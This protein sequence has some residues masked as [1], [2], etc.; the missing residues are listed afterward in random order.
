[1][2]TNSVRANSV[3]STWRGRWGALGLAAILYAVLYT[4]WTFFHWGGEENV[5]YIADFASVPIGLL[6]AFAAWR[7]V[8]DRQL[9]GG[10]RRAWLILGL[11]VF[12]SALGEALWFLYDALLKVQP[13]PSLADAFYLPFYPLVFLGLL[14]IPNAPMSREA[15]AKFWLDLAIV[16]TVA[17]MF[18]WYFIVAP[19]LTEAEGDLLSQVLAAAYPIG[20]LMAM[21][22]VTVLVLRR[23]D[24]TTR[25]ALL[26]FSCGLIV[27]LGS[28]LYFA[29]ASLFGDYAPGTF[30]E[31]GFVVGYALYLL[32]ALEQF[33]TTRGLNLSRGRWL[34]AVSFA[35]PFVAVALGYGLVLFAYNAEPDRGGRFWDLFVVAAVLALLVTAR[36]VVAVREIELLSGRLRVASDDLR[37]LSQDLERRV[38]DRTR[39]LALAA[40][41]SRNVSQVRN[42]D[43]LLAEAVELIR[44]QFDLYYTQV[45][46]TDP[47]GKSLILRAGTGST[48]DELLHRSHRLPVGPGSLHGRAASEKQ[49]C[50][51]ADTSSDASFHPNPLLPLTR[52]EMAIPLIV[53]EQVVGVLDLQHN[54][55]GAFTPDKLPA[56]EAL[57]GQLAVAI[58]NAALFA[59]AEQ[60]RAEVE[61]QARRLTQSGWS[62][63]LNAV[64]RSERVGYAFDANG[65]SPIQETIVPAPD[66]ST[67]AA[68]ILISGERVGTIQLEGSSDQTWTNDE[69]EIVN[70]IARQVAQ[71]VENLRLLAQAESYRREAERAAR[72]LTQESWQEYLE[73]VEATSNG[74]AYNLDQVKP[75]PEVEAAPANETVLT[76]A[77]SVHGETIGELAIGGLGDEDIATANL[78]EAV[79]GKLSAHIENL[80]LTEQ[81]RHAL[82]NLTERERTVSAVADTAVELL[83]RGPDAIPDVLAR[84]GGISEASRIYIFENFIDTDGLFCIRQTHEWVTEGVAPQIDNPELQHL[85]YATTL[86]RWQSM[87]G[88][89]EVIRGLVRDF[90]A[91]ERA[92]LEPQDIRSIL[93]IPMFTGKEF[94]GFIGFDDCVRDHIWG[95]YEIDLLQTISVSIVNAVIN[96]RL[97]SQSQKAL[98]ESQ[99]RNEE[100]ATINRVV[101]AAASSFNLQSILQAAATEIVEV[102]KARNT[103]IALLDKAREN[104]QV[105][106]DHSTS[107]EEPSAVGIV[108]PLANNPSSVQVIETKR[109]LVIANAQTDPLTES[110][111]ALLRERQTECLMIVPLLARGAV[112]GTIG[113]DTTDPARTFTSAE[114]ALVETIAGQLAGAIENIR[115]FEEVERNAAELSALFAA[116]T[117]VVLVYDKDGRYIRI[118]PTNP[119]LLYKPPK[120]MLGKTVYEVMPKPKAD[121]LLA[122]I[123]QT[124][125][126][127][128][129]VNAEYELNIGGIVLW[130]SANI[131][132][133]GEDAVFWVARDITERKRAEEEI[134]KFKLGIER[135]TDAV[136]MTDARGTIVYTN[137]AFERVYGYSPKETL[138][139]T[140]RILKSGLTSQENYKYFWDTLLAKGVVAGEI[141][142]KTKDSRLIT[143]EGSNN[144]ILDEAGNIVGFLGMHRDITERKQAEEALAKRAVELETVARVS[145]AAS[146]VLQVEA[147]LQEVVDLTRSSFNL[148]HAHIYLL[149][150]TGDMLALS[151]G[152]G[153]VGRK[154]VEIGRRIPLNHERSLVAR[155]ART[156][157]GVVANDVT[158]EPDFLPNP[159][160]PQTRS[161]MAVP[162]V[163]GDRLLGVFDVQS[164]IVNRFTDD[165]LR[166]QMTLAGQVAVALQN[167]QL[168][169]EQTATVARLRELDQLKS[170]FLANMSHELR[171]PLN[172]ILGFTEVLL[173][174]IDGDLTDRMDN[175]LKVVYKNGQ[176]L[177]SLIN[178]ILDMAKIEAGKMSLTIEPFNLQEVLE[179]VVEL[180]RPLA[181]NKSLEIHLETQA[182]DQFDLEADRIRLRQVMIN[183]VNN[184]IKFTEAGSV[185]INAVKSKSR[186]LVAI[187]DTGAGIPVN[188]LETIFQEFHQVDSSTTRKAGG[189]GLGLPISRHL[190]ELHNGRL[191]AESAGLGGLAGPD[192]GSIFYVELPI[193]SEYEPDEKR[194]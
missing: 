87:L 73:N 130:F 108:I 188:H 64:E 103:G 99:Q 173:E 177:L 79:A 17:G 22:G 78:V 180:A 102:L 157:R 21:A 125:E 37:S 168:Y 1:M 43:Q 96:A 45:Y 49:I 19:T 39:D 159:L 112:I 9:E 170:S 44:S 154:M 142:N 92:I 20:D 36:Q 181:Q 53:G 138:G 24:V 156:R 116:M 148:Y 129:S 89:G 167:A 50:S 59:Q 4:V 136:F 175:D 121:E 160:L 51:V 42:L 137:P 15:R 190:I 115:L 26:L 150:D 38:A 146:S 164:D 143:I 153:N 25:R 141:V 172:S 127:R 27:T 48:G 12:S 23:I 82:A 14:T 101:E 194:K 94:Y 71:Q 117:D 11:A 110:I 166:I 63:F 28:D 66:P 54:Q 6:A 52:S 41:I 158:Q 149:T 69:T 88:R 95:A 123:Q 193:H 35:L 7:V 151:A 139:Q 10:L 62:D 30:M 93:V 187:R 84:V 178:D 80:R 16:M 32:A 131:S 5:I 67:L 135:S 106:A 85:P 113:V 100:L 163:V 118:A 186:V 104:L 61:A 161:E 192:G 76:Q 191:W 34:E 55:P 126:T 72:R 97:F 155:A 133:L 111:H 107:P 152:A 31:A 65:L 8:A 185:S 119:A 60:A 13:F 182:T 145:T 109:S 120:D 147:L 68:P 165:D 46:L 81:T 33:S 40:D 58:Q 83:E 2:T 144:P 47:A 29:Y 179:E 91:T 183:L 98:S 140:P 122:Y 169:A 162:M 124:L 56:F 174:G 171:T 70:A 184:A 128:Q 77:L 86:P 176:H 132:P 18:V 134:L 3:W 114:V 189:T 105:V 74:Y 57:A 75:L 90:P